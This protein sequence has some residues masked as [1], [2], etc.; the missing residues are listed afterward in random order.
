MNFVSGAARA[1]ALT[2]KN[3]ALEYKSYPS[4][5]EN[6]LYI[7]GVEDG[8]PVHVLDMSGR[9]VMNSEVK[10][11]AVYVG[12]LSSGFYIVNVVRRQNELIRFKISKK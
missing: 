8:A 7:E 11:S 10:G 6:T 12:G 4:P 5:V 9:P 3:E 2:F 1:E